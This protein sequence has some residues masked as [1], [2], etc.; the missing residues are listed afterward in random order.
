MRRVLSDIME[1]A[2]GEKVQF[3]STRSWL[4]EWLKNREGSASATT[5]LRYKQVIRDFLEHLGVSGGTDD[6]GRHAWRCVRF[7]DKLKVGGRAE[8]TVNNTVKKVLNVPLRSGVEAGNHPGE[9]RG[10]CGQPERR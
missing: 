2:T 4:E 10:Q 5:M 9:S 8:S 6:C 1:N 3:Y 7:R